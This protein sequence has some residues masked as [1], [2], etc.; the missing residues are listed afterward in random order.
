MN[1]AASSLPHAPDPHPKPRERA[2]SA[3][4]RDRAT[5]ASTPIARFC[6]RLDAAFDSLRDEAAPS[7]HP[8]FARAL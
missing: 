1:H 6:T 7:R 5:P 3:P 4:C 8:A 2:P